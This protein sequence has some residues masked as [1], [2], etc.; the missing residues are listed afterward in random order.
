MVKTTDKK[1]NYEDALIDYLVI[2]TGIKRID[3][4]YVNMHVLNRNPTVL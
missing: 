4:I 3:V 1:N 2:L